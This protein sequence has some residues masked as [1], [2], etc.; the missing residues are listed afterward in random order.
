MHMEFEQHLLT[1]YRGERFEAALL[2]AF[3]FLASG[4]AFAM[5]RSVDENS[6]VKGMIYPVAFLALL[7]VLLG[8]FGVYNNSRRLTDMPAAYQQA[9]A[10]LVERETQRFEG[11]YGVNSWWLPLKLLWAVLIL[12][13]MTTTLLAR[14]DF[15]QGVAIGL[16]VIGTMGF[17]IDGFAHQRAKIYT[18]T[19]QI[20]NSASLI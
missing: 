4:V 12:V 20:E 10:E 15:V 5:W 8:S 2:A 3:G 17:V 9:P 1:Y 6:L 19:L 11:R 16:L 13:G 18:K 14:S 7:T